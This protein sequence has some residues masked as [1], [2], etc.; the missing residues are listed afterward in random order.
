M[1]TPIRRYFF[2]HYRTVFITVFRRDEP[3]VHQNMGRPHGFHE[4]FQGAYVFL[5]PSAK[6][7]SAGPTSPA[8]RIFLIDFFH[9]SGPIL[10]PDRRPGPRFGLA[11][12]ALV[13]IGNMK[14]P[15]RM[16]FSHSGRLPL[17]A[18]HSLGR[19]TVKKSTVRHDTN[20]RMT[21]E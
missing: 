6:C 13:E 1:D 2:I 16:R 20:A 10:S 9:V 11:K 4:K 8:Y 18:T 14:N 3:L 17:G 12:A 5:P 15:K 21:E 7:P 19:R